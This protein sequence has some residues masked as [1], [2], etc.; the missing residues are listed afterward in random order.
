VV[1]GWRGPN[2]EQQKCLLK[3]IFRQP[4]LGHEREYGETPFITI[5]QFHK[6]MGVE[7]SQ[8]VRQFKILNRDVLKPAVA[9]IN[10]V[11]DLRVEVEQQRKGRKVVALKFKIRRVAMLPVTD[12][13][14]TGHIFFLNDDMELNR[15]GEPFV[16]KM[17]KKSQSQ[18]K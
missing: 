17:L 11:S 2:P 13:F 14:T 18:L 10:K 12:A 6:L 8:Y 1:E 4:N 16:Q 15:Y 7:N 9:E 5:K 3:G